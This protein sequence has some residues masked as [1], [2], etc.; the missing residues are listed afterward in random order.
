[1]FREVGEGQEGE[2]GCAGAPG[3]DASGWHAMLAASAHQVPASSS[4]LS[5]FPHLPDGEMAMHAH[6]CV[7][8]ERGEMG[9]S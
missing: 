8:S 5:L 9:S 4:L 3:L 6:V 1:M 2:V 7:E